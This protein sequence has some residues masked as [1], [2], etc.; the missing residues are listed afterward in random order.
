MVGLMTSTI[1]PS[2]LDR[3]STFGDLLRFLRRRAGITQM[4]LAAAVGYS[5]GQISRLEQNLRLPDAT[6]VEARFVSALDLERDSAAIARLIDLARNMRREDAPALGLCPYK[7]LKYFDE[8]DAELFIGREA[9]TAKLVGRVRGLATGPEN[10]TGRFLAIVGA[11]G[12]GKSSLVRAGLI[13][14]LRWDEKTVDWRICLLTPTASPLDELASEVTPGNRSLVSVADF[15]DDL[16]R[17]PRSLQLYARREAKSQVG[18]R[19]LFVVDQ[20]EEVFALCRS[21]EERAA[22]IANLLTAA[23]DPDGPT[24]VIITLRADFYAHCATYP[25]LREALARD[26]EYIGVMSPHELR[27]TIEEPARRGHWE[28]EPGLVDLLLRDV[29]G[30]PG[31]LPLLSHALLETWER[32]RGH[33]LTL[34]GYTSSGGVRGAIAETAEAVFSDQFTPAQQAIA[35]RIFLRLTELGDEMSAADTRRRATFSELVLKPEESDSTRAVLKALADARLVTLSEEGAEVAHEALIREW[36]K[37]RVWLE[38]NREG[39]RLHR[40]M[41]ESA[42]EWIRLGRDADILYRG[43]RLARAREWAA[44][45]ADEMNDLEREFLTA[46]T[47]FSEQEAAQREARRQSELAAARKRLLYLAGAFLIAAAMAV[48]AFFSRQQAQQS[49]VAAQVANQQSMANAATAQAEAQARAT[50]QSIAQANFI[51]A[52]VLRLAAEAN[53]LLLSPGSDANLVALLSIRSMNTQYTPQGDQALEGA[54]TLPFPRL[55]FNG[56]TG[57]ISYA[58]YSPDGRYIVTSS[59]DHT[60]RLWDAQ[61]GK[62][63]RQ[64]IGHTD[65]VLAVAFSPDGKQI[66][67]VSFDQTLRLWDV[68]T[69]KTLQTISDPSFLYKLTFSPDGRYI[70]FSGYANTAHL[71]DTHTFQIVRTYTQQGVVQ[72]LSLSSDGRYLLTGSKLKAAH[73]W[74]VQTGVEVRQFLPPASVRQCTF[75]PDGKSILTAGEDNIIRMWD[76]N[77]GQEVRTFVGHTSELA[78]LEFSPDGKYILSGAGDGTVRLWN[79]QTGDQ[80]RALTV[81]TGTAS[82]NNMAAIFSP[83]GKQIFTAQS[84]TGLLWDTNNVLN[85]GLPEFVTPNDAVY[86]VAFSPDGKYVLTASASHNLARLWDVQTRQE[87]RDFCCH[88]DYVI[89]AAFSPDGKYVL[90]GGG[91]AD[92]TARLWD[93]QTGKELLRLE[94]N[95]DDYG[96]VVAFSPQGNYF[97][98]SSTHTYVWDAKTGKQLQM[99]VGHTDRVWA[100]AFSPDSRT[101]L[102]GSWDGTARLWDIQTGKQLQIF[103]HPADDGLGAVAFSPDGKTI[104]TGGG[105]HLLRLWDVDTAKEIREFAGHT[106]VITSVTFSP[107]GKYVLS[108]GGD[109]TARLWDVATGAELRRFVVSVGYADGAVFSP[110]GKYILTGDDGGVARIWFIDYHDEIQY[111]CSRLTRDFTDQERKL[112]DIPGNSPTCGKP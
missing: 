58:A 54:M 66:A 5:D 43:A 39:L 23:A 37:L 22:F 45:H 106:D 91:N 48:A 11:S 69:G 33:T 79:A 85:T 93:I 67:T 51:R 34:S 29:G 9:L 64:F 111:L 50:Q 110:D 81:P 84:K 2:T 16:R 90:T 109:G 12:S 59:V 24:V 17:E 47:A 108:G 13:P 7:G 38:E 68:Q 21:E 71:L 25:Q 61:T 107:D 46:S 1:P 97:A 19:L 88:N 15:I 77:T 82:I 70:I 100:L 99:F 92:N 101:L 62:E 75:S 102:T 41:T 18:F 14:A 8:S 89:N 42:H 35:R 105:D 60:V 52:D 10:R 103:N 78:H 3:F 27:R 74:D 63:V 32:R 44:S 95:T 86:S 104:L 49:A 65:E 28:L 112:Y 40:Q 56:H 57:D 94:A 87:I 20:F 98:T 80:I 31:A 96:L 76:I 83:D 72:C 26:Q 4:E 55:V 30:E 53:K 36:P 73:L 6:T